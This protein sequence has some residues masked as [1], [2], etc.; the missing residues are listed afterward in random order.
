MRKELTDKILEGFEAFLQGSL[1]D[2]N[3]ALDSENPEEAAKKAK[4]ILERYAVM[5]VAYSKYLGVEVPKEI[6]EKFKEIYKE[7]MKAEEAV[8]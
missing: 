7:K 1:E 4:Y 5:K 3:Q 2:F 6:D 8:N